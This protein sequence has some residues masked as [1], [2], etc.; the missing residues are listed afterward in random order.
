MKEKVNNKSME[1]KKI[2]IDKNDLKVI[3]HSLKTKKHKVLC[4]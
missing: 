2:K 1:N 4:I 3:N